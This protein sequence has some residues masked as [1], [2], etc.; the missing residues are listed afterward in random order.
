MSITAKMLFL[1]DQ[2]P[3]QKKWLNKIRH[4][5]KMVELMELAKQRQNV[6]RRAGFYEYSGPFVRY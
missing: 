2:L 1:A 3:S 6:Y 5:T 4:I